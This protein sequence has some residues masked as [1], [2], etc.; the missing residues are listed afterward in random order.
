M[1]TVKR[2]LHVGTS[3]MGIIKDTL[4]QRGKAKQAKY[5]R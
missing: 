3:Q 4:G 5:P 2:G 1:R